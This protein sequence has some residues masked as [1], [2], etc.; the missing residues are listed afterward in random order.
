MSNTHINTRDPRT[1]SLRHAYDQYL[2]RGIQVSELNDVSM[3]GMGYLLP[4]RLEAR[5]VNAMNTISVLR[6]LCTEVTTVGDRSLPIVNGHGKA[7]WVPEGHP[8]PM[9]KDAFDRVNLNSHKL[10]AIIRVTNELL[11]DSAVDIEAYLAA[12]FADRLAVSEEEAFITGDGEDKPLGLIR[13]A[14]VGCMTENAGSVSVEDVLNLIFSVPEK[15]RRN[16]ILLMNDDT[17]LALYKQC[18]AQGQSLWLGKDDTFFGYRIV[19]CASMPNA[20]SGS[21]PVLFGDF[22]K[23]YINNNGNRSI[24]RLN[25]LFIANDHVGFLMAERVGIKLMVQ[26]A[27]KSL[28]VA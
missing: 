20:T 17:L 27:I 11:K 24:K 26:D 18:A 7:A 9:V 21:I 13:Q 28:K 3:D 4:Q 10:A 19:R 1:D 8:I 25:Q 12:T 5:L 2:R 6:P 23:V 16:G 15:H 14:K 22:K